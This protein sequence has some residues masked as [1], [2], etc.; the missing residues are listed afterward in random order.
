MVRLFLSV[1]MVGSTQFKAR[2]GN[3]RGHGWLDTFRTFF[4]NFPLMLAGQVGFA[5][6][7]D[8]G[9]TPSVEV[10]KVMGDEVIF[11]ATPATAGEITVLLCALLRTMNLYE[12]RYFADLPLRLKGTV[13]AAHFGSDNIE[14]EIPELSG[15]DGVRSV[16]FIGP[17]IDLGFR[18]SKYSR[19]AS[20]VL[21]FDVAD[22]LLGA[23][24]LDEVALYLMGAE[25]LKGVMFG[26]PYP[27]IWMIE[28][29]ERFN[30][31]PWEVENCPLMRAAVDATPTPAALIERSIADMRLY[32]RKM[33][34]V[35][36]PR[37]ALGEES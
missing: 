20:L 11:V 19:P 21:S 33:H 26:R 6:L 8:D 9:A 5:F 22:L 37:F 35:D 23:P 12:G 7:E 25:E 30:F 13:W 24:N 18:I 15:G 3:G 29:G 4:T 14:L 16:D 10:W 27:I 28:A 36:R 31:M 34:G 1:D 32:L 2:H 17:D